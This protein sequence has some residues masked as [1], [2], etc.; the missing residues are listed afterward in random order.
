MPE[1]TDHILIFSVY[2]EPSAVNGII[3]VT[4]HVDDDVQPFVIAI[5]H[6]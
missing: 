2:Q 1:Q 6:H 3:A 4:V 5:L